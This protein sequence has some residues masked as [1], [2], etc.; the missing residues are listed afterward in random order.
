MSNVIEVKNLHK[1]FG[2]NTVL[3][4]INFTVAKGE[5]V[6]L[7]GPSGGGKSNRLRCLIRLEENDTG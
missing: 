5:K 2:T 1:A 3:K 4:D 6:V 7:I